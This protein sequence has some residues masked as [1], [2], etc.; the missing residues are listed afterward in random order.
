MDEFTLLKEAFE[1]AGMG[2]DTA[3][4]LAEHINDVGASHVREIL[5]SMELY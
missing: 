1:A 3:S 2:E 5:N 4:R